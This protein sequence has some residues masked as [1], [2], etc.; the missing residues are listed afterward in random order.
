MAGLL[1]AKDDDD[2]DDDDE[3]DVQLITST[4]VPGTN[5]RISDNYGDD[6]VSLLQYFSSSPA[7]SSYENDDGADVENV[8]SVTS[9]SKKSFAMANNY[10]D[11]RSNASTAFG[12]NNFIVDTTNGSPKFTSGAAATTTKSSSSSSSSSSSPLKQRFV[13]SPS[14]WSN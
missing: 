4:S 10:D 7:I 12:N 13:L 11:P 5:K 2:D 14:N 8:P 6:G 3:S 9:P 1:F